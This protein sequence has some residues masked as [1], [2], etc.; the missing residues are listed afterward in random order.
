[1]QRKTEEKDRKQ[2]TGKVDHLGKKN[3][4]KDR[5]AKT[6]IKKYML[7]IFYINRID[8]NKVKK[9]EGNGIEVCTIYLCCKE[10][11]SAGSQGCQHST[12][13]GNEVILDISAFGFWQA[14][15]V[16]LLNISFSTQTPNNIQTKNSPQ[17]MK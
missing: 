3:T 15:Q 1:M 9:E 11:P 2:K 13:A 16:K 8:N 6:K 10:N 17:L 14:G 5:S 12:V 7:F 4:E